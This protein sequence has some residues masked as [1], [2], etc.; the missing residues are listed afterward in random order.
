MLAG[1][2]GMLFAEV[3]WDQK[4]WKLRIDLFRRV[5]CAASVRSSIPQEVLEGHAISILTQ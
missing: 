1:K 4:A 5:I 3:D 2:A